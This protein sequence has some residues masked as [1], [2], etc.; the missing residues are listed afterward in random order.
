MHWKFEVV[1]DNSDMVQ[2]ELN[3][4]SWLIVWNVDTCEAYVVED[5]LGGPWQLAF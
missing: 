2:E 1:Y 4:N 3:E 5:R